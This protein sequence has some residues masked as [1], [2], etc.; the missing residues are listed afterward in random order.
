MM[1]LRKLQRKIFKDRRHVGITLYPTSQCDTGCAHCID[2]SDCK[3]P[4][5]FTKELAEKIV[6]EARSERWMLSTLFTGG[7]EP[8]MAPEL[9]EIADTFGKYERMYTFG[10]ITSGF[11]DAEA[12]RKEK[13]EKLLK[14]PYAKKITVEQSFSLY[15]KSFPERLSNILRSITSIRRSSYL[16]IR[17]CMSLDNCYETQKS[18]DDVI[19]NLAKE[20][21]SETFPLPIGWQDDFSTLHYLFENKIIGDKIAHRLA[22]ESFLAPSWRALKTKEGGIVTRT[23]PISF[24]QTGRG[25]NISQSS[26]AKSVCYTTSVDFPDTYL[27]VGPDGSVYPDCSCYPISHMRLGKIGK[28]SLVEL[29]RRKDL[30]TARITQAL[31]ADKRM[32]RWGTKE[33]CDVCKQIVFEKGIDLK[34]T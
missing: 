32:C 20:L 2:N 31:L 25:E 28:D 11:T 12:D 21:D 7:G 9:L 10:I 8:L 1:F 6:K 4:I 16:Q 26:Y 3:N 13:F 5:H 19:K 34:N 18:I 17:A 24:E 29:V 14:K 15:H 23:Q 30:F 27:I 33:A 22:V